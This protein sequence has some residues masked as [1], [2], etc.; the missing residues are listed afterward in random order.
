M[1]RDDGFPVMDLSTDYVNDP[2][3]RRLHRASPELLAAA[4]MAYTSAMC[5]SWKAGHKVK[6]EDGWPVLLPY[7]RAVIK[8]LMDAGFVDARGYI[9]PKS[10]SAWFEPAARR[11]EKSRE[12]WRRYNEKRDADTTVVPRGSDADTATSV[13]SGLSVPTEPSVRPA[14]D[15]ADAFSDYYSLTTRYPKGRT[16]E[17]LRELVGEFGDHDVGRSLATE[18]RADSDLKTFLSRT[19]ARLRSDA[20]A[21]ERARSK[22]KPRMIRSAEEI[23]EAERQRKAILEEWSIIKEINA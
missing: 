3:W 1:S 9:R 22:P 18:W 17:W 15:D 13:P 16:E 12:R 8:A 20:H 21:A 7:D 6:V 14:S 11:R 4:F 23:A 5:E 10:W 2:K 19:E